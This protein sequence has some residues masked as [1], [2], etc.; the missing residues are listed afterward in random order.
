MSMIQTVTGLKPADS[1][2]R[3][4]AHEHVFIDLY[5]VYQPHRDMRLAD[6]ALAIDEVSAFADCGGQLLVELTTPDLGRRPDALVRVSQA[7][8]VDI[9]MGTGRYRSPF[10]EENLDRVPTSELA[11][12]F[13]NDIREGV[14][15]VRPGVVGEIG[16]DWDF[17]SSIEERVHRAA[18][19]AALETGLSLITHSLGSDVGMAQLRLFDEEGLPGHRVAIGHADT[20]VDRD[21]HRDVA[22]SGAYLIFDTVRGINAYDTRRTI[23]MLE[24]AIE[25]GYEDRVMLGHDVCST[26]HCRAYGGNGYTYVHGGFEVEMRDAGFPAAAIAGFLGLNAVEFLRRDSAGSG[27]VERGDEAR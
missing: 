10:Y 7:T 1:Y 27:S 16:T 20:F 4:L 25:E 24:W 12:V 11:N 23:D 3:V 2:S 9:V 13:I 15:G 26:G 21:Y 17:V 14:N 6:E 18:A 19:T 5:R 8:G 22:Q